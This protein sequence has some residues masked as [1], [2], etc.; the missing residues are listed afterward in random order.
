MSVDWNKPIR[1]RNG[2]PAILHT[3][4]LYG[5]YPYLV[6]YTTPANESLV[7]TYT[8]EG[9]CV[10]SEESDI[11]IVNTTEQESDEVKHAAMV[12]T[13]DRFLYHDCITGE[14]DHPTSTDCALWFFKDATEITKEAEG[15]TYV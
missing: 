9:K 12:H 4:E 13:L 1:T 11:D 15:Q 8:L 14:C 6:T 7:N 10:S 2:N 5:D 3:R